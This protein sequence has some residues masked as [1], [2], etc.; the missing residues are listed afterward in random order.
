MRFFPAIISVI[1]VVTAFFITAANAVT[2]NIYEIDTSLDKAALYTCLDNYHNG[3]WNGEEC[4]GYGWFKGGISY[5]DPDNCYDA[6]K[7]CIENS[8]NSFAS[9]MKCDDYEVLAHCWMGYH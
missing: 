1:V 6:C 9:S 4:G 7:T 3:N 2:C 8:I 5:Q